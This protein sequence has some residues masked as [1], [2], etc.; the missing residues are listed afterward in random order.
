MLRSPAGFCCAAIAATTLISAAH[1]Q[2]DHS[3][4]PVRAGTWRYGTSATFSQADFVDATGRAQLTIRCSRASRRVA[5]VVPSVVAVP[6]IS[7]WT[8]STARSLAAAH[9][10]AAAQLTAEL[11]VNDPALDALSFSRGSFSVT[12]QGA[13]P[14]VV[15]AWAEPA[16][17][18][19]DC[20]N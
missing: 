15:P 12:V 14:I 6:A 4:L 19:E 20:R 9:N 3:N 5:I 10:P 17:A 16:R 11:A 18:I 7:L 2:V 8:T 13:A 1:S